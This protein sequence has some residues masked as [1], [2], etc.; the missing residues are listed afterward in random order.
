MRRIPLVLKGDPLT[1]VKIHD[2][3]KFASSLSLMQHMDVKEL[4]KAMRWKSSSAFFRHYLTL[5]P[6][7][8]QAVLVP[9]GTIA[10]DEVV[11]DPQ[12]GPSGV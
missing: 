5:T 8:T 1:K 2:I 10:A 12:E 11:D 4:L 9:G 6:R 7:P 3:C